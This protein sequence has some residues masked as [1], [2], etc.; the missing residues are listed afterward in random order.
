MFNGLVSIVIPA[1]NASNY[2]KEAIESALSQTYRNIE[3]IV[4][5]DGSMDDGA[6]EKIALSYGD[7]IRYFKKENGGCASA[8]NYGISVMK[9][10]YFSWL[11]HDD[12]Y[13]PQKIEQLLQLLNT[14]SVD[15]YRKCILGSN[16]LILNS[17]GK[18]KRNLFNNSVGMISPL[19]AFHETLNVKTINGCSLLIPK[20]VFDTID[21]FRTDYKHLLDR[22][23]WMRIAIS[24]FSFCF[25]DEPLVFSR[26][27]NNQ[28]TIQSQELL[29]DEEEKLL[30]EYI[31][32]ALTPKTISFL[33]PLC[34]FALK[35]K[36]YTIGNEIIDM[37]K[38]WN[39]YN[40]KVMFLSEKYYI[41]GLLRAKIR[42]YYKSL[43]RK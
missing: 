28:V 35:R 36:H 41:R 8:L 1:Y 42:N 14:Y 33:E 37:L 4:V 18:I 11:S 16:D 27:H 43:I 10:E 23:L 29:Y 12:L 24:N 32:K 40:I 5:N 22:E 15:D 9:G 38:K 26:V 20:S 39:R 7:K 30:S 19:Q 31:E 2:L 34:Y 17:Q 6:T 21:G 13:K 3:I 25:A